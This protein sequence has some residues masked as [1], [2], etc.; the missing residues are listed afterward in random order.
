MGS[1]TMIFL[2]VFFTLTCILHSVL[3]RFIL[4]WLN[5]SHPLAKTASLVLFSFLAISF[6]A[7]FFLLRWTET[8][9]TILF[10]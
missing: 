5:V 3:Y 2:F 8:R 6:M 4:R 1:G 9:W 7:A 10:Y